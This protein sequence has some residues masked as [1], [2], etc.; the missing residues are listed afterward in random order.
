MGEGLVIAKLYERHLPAM[1][2]IFDA[3]RAS[4]S[5]VDSYGFITTF[6]TQ[7]GLVAT[8]L[9]QQTFATIKGS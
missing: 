9:P 5:Q 1:N 8:I 3:E 2:Q 4:L 7:A 6:P